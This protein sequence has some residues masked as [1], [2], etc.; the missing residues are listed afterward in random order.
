MTRITFLKIFIIGDFLR[1]DQFLRSLEIQTNK[2][3]ERCEQWLG[4]SIVLQKGV[5]DVEFDFLRQIIKIKYDSR[6]N[7]AESIRQFIVSIGYDAGSQKA[8]IQ[9]RKILRDCCFTTIPLCK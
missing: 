2:I 5:R 3:C 8:D 4:K 7:T 9:K 1:E 6:K